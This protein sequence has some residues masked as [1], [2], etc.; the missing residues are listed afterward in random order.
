[1]NEE[2]PITPSIE[3]KAARIKRIY[4]IKENFF[5]TKSYMPML[6]KEASNRHSSQRRRLG[7]KEAGV[8]AQQ[9]RILGCSMPYLSYVHRRA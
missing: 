2:D 9:N 8:Y 3:K 4:G 7:A 5:A 6:Q 1:V